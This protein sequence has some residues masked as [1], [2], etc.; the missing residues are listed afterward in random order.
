M[1]F[2]CGL[3]QCMKG[4]GGGGGGKQEPPQQYQ[5][6]NI[7]APQFAPQ[8]QQ[9][10]QPQA[11]A[12]SAPVAFGQQQQAMAVAYAQPQPGYGAPVAQGYPPQQQPQQGYPQQGYPQQGYPQ[13]YTS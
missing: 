13:Q 4:G 10:G 2:P 3:Y 5:Q 9:P 12:Q 1:I 7:Q 8:F 6:G 11:F